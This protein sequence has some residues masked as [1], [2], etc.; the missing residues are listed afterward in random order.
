MKGWINYV[1]VTDRK[2]SQVNCAL[3]L[4]TN[5]WTTVAPCIFVIVFFLFI[6]SII[7]LILFNFIYLFFFNINE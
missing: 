2:W 1:V 4:R 5:H 3:H 7:Y 6:C